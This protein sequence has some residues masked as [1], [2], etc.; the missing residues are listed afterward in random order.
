MAD[1][2]ALSQL[3]LPIAMAVG[4]IAAWRMT[5]RQQTREEKPGWRDTSLDD[6]RRERDQ[7]VERERKQRGA[8]PEMK[9]GTEQEQ[10]AEQRHERMGG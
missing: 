4:G 7:T 5:R 9:Q 1:I 10:A 3:G 8:S 6:W 2:T